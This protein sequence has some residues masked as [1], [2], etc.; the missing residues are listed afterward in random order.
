MDDVVNLPCM[1]T[2]VIPWSRLGM[3]GRLPGEV[4]VSKVQTLE[5]QLV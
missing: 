4:D 2:L 3:T 1:T 5:V